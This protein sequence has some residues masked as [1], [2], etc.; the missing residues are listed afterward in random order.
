MTSYKNTKIMLTNTET[1]FITI[2]TRKETARK[3]RNQK[4]ERGKHM[5][6]TAQNYRIANQ[7][8]E[9]LAR[10]SCT[11]KQSEEILSFVGSTIRNTST[12]QRSEPL[13]NLL[14]RTEDLR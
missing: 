13:T 4:K 1:V 10:E 9:L 6:A 14:N 12:V 3:A 8:I 7:V 2:T 11:V 5:E